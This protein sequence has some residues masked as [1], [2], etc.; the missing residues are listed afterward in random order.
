MKAKYGFCIGIVCLA[1]GSTLFAQDPT[2]VDS[3][4]YTVVSRMR[5]RSCIPTPTWWLSS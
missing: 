5:N 4:H 1:V 3:K 2:K